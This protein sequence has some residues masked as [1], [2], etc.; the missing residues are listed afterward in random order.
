MSAELIPIDYEP[1]GKHL[2]ETLDEIRE[3]V[4]RGEISS[5]AVAYVFRDGSTGL[6]HSAMPSRSTLIGAVE[7]LKFRLLMDGQ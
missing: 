1:P 4:E 5:I 7:R 3:M 2:A 6:A